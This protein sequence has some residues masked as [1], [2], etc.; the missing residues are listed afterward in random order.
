MRPRLVDVAPLDLPAVVTPEWAW[1]GSTGAGVKVA[2]VDSG[3][4]PSHP[5][6][7][8]V[9]GGIGIEHAPDEPG[10]V[11]FTAD[12]EDLCGHGTACASVIRELAPE[13]E[14]HSVRVLGAQMTGRGVVFAAGIRWAIDHG[15]HVVNL[16]LSTGK[17]EFFGTF[18][19][20][21]DAAYFRNVM[22]VSAANNAPMPSYPSLY[23]SVLSVA[24]TDGQD[25][26]RFSYNPDPPVEFG[27]PGIDVPVG[28]LGGET[29]TA[30][31]N[32]FAAPCI[33]GLTARIL[34]KHPGLAPF[35][36]KTI[37]RELADNVGG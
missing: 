21:A 30:T 25:R 17:K 20:L 32:S 2:V 23:S 24:A 7:G 6:V 22:L 12:H 29:I 34:G 37:L 28:W 5:L 14:I 36:V 3:V 8:H 1:G 26:E 15:M 19:E 9:A 10:Q 18:H 11:R 33:A 16:S 27:A 31:G 13:A 35:Q 4:D